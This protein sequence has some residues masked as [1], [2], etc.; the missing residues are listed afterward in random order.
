MRAQRGDAASAGHGRTGGTTRSRCAWSWPR[1]NIRRPTWTDHS[2]QDQGGGENETQCYTAEIRITPLPEEPG[3]QYYGMDDD[4]SVPVLS[5][6]RPP[7]LAEVRPQGQLERHTGIGYE[8]V[9]TRDAPVLQKLGV[10]LVQDRILQRLVEQTL[11]NDT[12]QVIEAP[13]ISCPAQHPLASTQMA[14]VASQS[15]FQQHS[16][17]QSVDIPVHG[18]GARPADLQGFLEGQSPTARG[19]LNGGGLQ[20]FPPGQGSSVSSSVQHEDLRSSAAV[21]N[22]AERSSD[23]VLGAFH[24]NKTSAKVVAQSSARVLAH[25]GSSAQRLTSRPPLFVTSPGSW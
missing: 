5:A 14:E 1:W 4:D 21:I 2:H 16:V 13:K 10:G 24:R 23:W 17:E 3:T 7:L 19:W 12:E 9:L 22:T 8:L 15:E 25:L 11:T 20:G 18:G 6:V